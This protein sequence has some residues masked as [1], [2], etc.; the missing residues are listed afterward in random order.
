M[1][2]LLVVAGLL[3]F[4]LFCFLLFFEGVSGIPGSLNHKF[5]NIVGNEVRLFLFRVVVFILEGL[6]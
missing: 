2:K 1:K 4:L 5:L 6:A 3:N